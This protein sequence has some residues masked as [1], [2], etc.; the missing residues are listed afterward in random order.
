[1]MH[2]QHERATHTLGSAVKPAAKGHIL[3]GYRLYDTL[4][5]QTTG[6]ENRSGLLVPR[7]GVELPEE[8]HPGTC[9]LRTSAADVAL[10]T[11]PP[12]FV[13]THRT[14]ASPGTAHCSHHPHCHPQP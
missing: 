12:A 4:K 6:T 2:G 1:M 9:R 7:G 5:R 11:Q 3:S 14:C 8:L 10:G 13:K